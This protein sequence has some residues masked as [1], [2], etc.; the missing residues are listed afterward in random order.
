MPITW[1]EAKDLVGGKVCLLGNVKPAET[2]LRGT[3]QA[4]REE[5]RELVAQAAASPRGLILSSGCEVPFNTPPANLD[6][7]IEAARVYGRS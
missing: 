6:G 5:V 4:V 7:M 2:L 3:P 1:G